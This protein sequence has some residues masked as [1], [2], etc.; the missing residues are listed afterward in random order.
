M[1]RAVLPIVGMLAIACAPTAHASSLWGAIAYFSDSQHGRFSDYGTQTQLILDIQNSWQGAGYVTFPSGKCGAVASYP[2]LGS[3]KFST[4]TGAS[5]D[6]ATSQAI[7]GA[8]TDKYFL[9]D[10]F[11]Q[12]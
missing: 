5:L 6:A 3:T 10:A 2:L 11:C 8:V 4:G 7:A 12:R 1:K 9:L